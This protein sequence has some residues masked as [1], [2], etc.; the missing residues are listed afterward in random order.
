MGEMDADDATLEEQM[1]RDEEARPDEQ[2][3]MRPEGGDANVVYVEMNV[4]SLEPCTSYMM[5]VTHL[6]CINDRMTI[7]VG[8]LS[9]A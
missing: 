6:S 5:Q 2:T 7:S 9:V 3:P 8:N 4:T 1:L